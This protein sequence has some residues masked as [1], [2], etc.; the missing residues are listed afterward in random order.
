MENIKTS[1]VLDWAKQFLA[2]A[3]SELTPEEIKEQQKF[4]SLEHHT[5]L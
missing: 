4:A 1:D 5:P 2:K 3:E